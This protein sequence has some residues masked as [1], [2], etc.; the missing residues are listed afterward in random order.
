MYV[1]GLLAWLGWTLFYGSP[2][3]LIGLALLWALFTFRV[4][5]REER[6]L[7]D[8]FGEEYLDYKRTVRRW[9]GRF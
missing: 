8:L 4:I 2:A 9:L 6:Q 7:E 1:A 5:P 3:V